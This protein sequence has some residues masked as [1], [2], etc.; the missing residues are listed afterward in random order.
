MKSLILVLIMLVS[1]LCYGATF[2][3]IGSTTYGSDDTNNYTIRNIGQNTYIDTYNTQTYQQKTTVCRT[4]G[5][6]VYCD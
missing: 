6:V 4:V 5:S 2:R 1:G 3:T